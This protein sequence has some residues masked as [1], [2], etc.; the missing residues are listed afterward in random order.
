[1]MINEL[2]LIFGSKSKAQEIL[3]LLKGAKEVVRQ[4]FYDSELVTVEE[5]CKK[6][7][8]FL[9]KSRFKVLMDDQQE[10]FSNKGIRLKEEDPRPGMY[11]VY[12]SKEERLALLACYAE[13]MNRSRELGRILG[14][15]ECCIDFFGSHFSE[16]KTNLEHLPTNPWTNLSKRAQDF[17]LISHF[18]CNSDCKESIILSKKYF[19]I[20]KETDAERA[21]EILKALRTN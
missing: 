7:G 21:T 20:I 2:A 18:P 14:Y 17:V 3:L 16:D 5:F 15:P 11:F 4:G 9:I 19:S 8:L 12:L 1:M 6:N 13:M 10:I